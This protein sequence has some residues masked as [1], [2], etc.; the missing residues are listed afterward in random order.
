MTSPFAR[1]F[2]GTGDFASLWTC[3][4]PAG[5]D[6]YFH[7]FATQNAG[8]TCHTRVPEKKGGKGSSGHF[9][10]DLTPVKRICSPHIEGVC[11]RVGHK[12]PGAV[13]KFVPKPVG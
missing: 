3:L 10:P 8:R 1:A 4:P 2:R 5:S 12:S 6:D 11:V 9:L 13:I 7:G